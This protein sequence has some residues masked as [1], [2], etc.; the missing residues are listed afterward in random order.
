[1]VV[2]EKAR[3]IGLLMIAVNFKV[4][5]L[6]INFVSSLYSQ[7]ARLVHILLT[8][9]GYKKLQVHMYAQVT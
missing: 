5:R 6:K 2:Q 3:I 1:M 9:K 7:M 8:S 4:A